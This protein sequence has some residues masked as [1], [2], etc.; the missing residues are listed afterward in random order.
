[1]MTSQLGR[2][3]LDASGAS[4][5]EMTATPDPAGRYAPIGSLLGEVAVQIRGES[6]PRGDRRPEDFSQAE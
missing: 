4:G 5:D 3:V 1:M 6:R 2:M